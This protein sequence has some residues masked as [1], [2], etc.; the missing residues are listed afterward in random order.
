MTE[1]VVTAVFHGATLEDVI[2]QARRELGDT[3]MM[4]VEF[5]KIDVA[6]VEAST[7]FK[8][9]EPTPE[10]IDKEG[11]VWTATLTVKGRV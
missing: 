1:T 11:W 8:E 9:G 5:S 4:E 6:R 10:G 2:N 3:W 7:L